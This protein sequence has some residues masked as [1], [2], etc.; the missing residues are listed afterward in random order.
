MSSRKKNIQEKIR[1]LRPKKPF[2]KKSAF[3]YSVLFITVAVAAAYFLL[4]F[5]V[6][7]IKQISVFGA[8]KLDPQTIEKIVE[9][10]ITQN[11]INIG[12]WNLSSKSI[13]LAK[14]AQIQ[15]S[16]LNYDATIEAVAVAK[17]WP[18]KLEIIIKEREQIA[19]FCQEDNCFYID[20]NGIIF[21]KYENSG[22][23]LIVRQNQQ[24]ENLSIGQVAVQKN[25]MLAIYEIEKKLKENFQIN[26]TNALISTPIRL[27]VQTGEGWQIYFDIDAGSNISSQLDKLDLLLKQEISQDQ[28]P[29]L[30]Y[31]D[32]RFSRAYYK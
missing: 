1:R 25:I 13:F 12:N 5:D 11:F 4:F 14:S 18:D 20:A 28:R 3:W 8:Q 32:L 31:I 23:S 9:K 6:I 22:D 24:Q 17:K 15:K 10:S 7:Q 29:N 16:I 27:N 2:Y 30:Q 19:I 26:L 21:E